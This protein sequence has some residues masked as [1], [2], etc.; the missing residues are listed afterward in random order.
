MAATK[1]NTEKTHCPYGHAYTPENTKVR[2][3]SEKPGPTRVCR[4][5]E[6]GWKWRLSGISLIWD[7]FEALVEQQ[8]NRCLVCTVEFSDP[9][10]LR[11]V[12][13]Y[14]VPDHDRTTGRVRGILCNA[15]NRGLGHFHD[16]PDLLVAAAVYLARGE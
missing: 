10:G 5:C 11:S 3:S 15:C 14:P 16:D 12:P 13:T 2:R 7:E 8:G 9:M 1:T 6:R 4:K